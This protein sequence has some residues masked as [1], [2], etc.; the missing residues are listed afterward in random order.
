MTLASTSE[1]AEPAKT[2]NVLMVTQSQGFV[3]NPVKRPTD[4]LA[5][6]EIAVTQLGQKVGW[7]DVHCTQDV[8]ADFTKENLQNY[9]LV[10]FYTTGNLPI[11]K[12]DLDYFF[13]EWLQQ[14]GHGF[15]GVHSAADTFKDYKPYWDMVGGTF[16][17]H[18]WNAGEMV[19][20]AVH[21]SEHPAVRH[22]APEFEIKDEIYQYK[23]WQPEKVR[24]LMSLDMAKTKL[25]KPYLVP[26]A[27]VK[28]YGKGRM[29]FTNLGHN[30][31]TW[32]DPRFVDHLENGM[33]W[34]AGLI[35]G[36]ATP[37]PELSEM[38]EKKAKTD[39]EAA[40]K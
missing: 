38:L 14:P 40:G 28:P 8:A 27:W 3:H 37:N 24:V 10:L 5:T 33:K 30:D 35:E 9:Q 29:F 11:A 13:E 7:F 15:V 6:S 34:A 18:P 17:G 23:N 4:K 12:A 22:L 2:V 19:T 20:I 36:D 26:V 32:A 25:K 16:N 1:A 31:G 21:D 39:T